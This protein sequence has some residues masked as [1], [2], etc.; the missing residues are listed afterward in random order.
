M[1][2]RN[3]VAGAAAAA[4]ASS[5]SMHAEGTR[6]SLLELRKF[7][8]RNT[9]D[10]QRGR[11]TDFVARAYVPAL[12]RAGAGPI[13]LFSPLVAPDAPFLLLLAAYPSCDAFDQAHTK[14]DADEAYLKETE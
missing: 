14:L 1:N 5:L 7:L 9:T 11:L 6:P 12:I 10:N 2:R 3:F 8:L 13:G 4:L